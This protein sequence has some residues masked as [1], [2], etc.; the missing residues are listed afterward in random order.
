MEQNEEAKSAQAEAPAAAQAGQLRQRTL[1]ALPRYRSHK[2]VAAA[3][4]I[5]LEQCPDG[6]MLTLEVPAPDGGPGKIEQLVGETWPPTDHP[7]LRSLDLA[8]GCDSKLVGGYYVRYDDDY[9]SWSPSG[10]F[11]NGYDLVCEP[12]TGSPPPPAVSTM[13]RMIESH[14]VNAAN[15]QLHIAVCDDPGSGG[16]NHR[17]EIGGFD[18]QSNPSRVRSDVAEERAQ[19]LLV[20][21]FQ[22]GAIKEAGVNGVTHEALLAIVIDR[23]KAW[24]AGPFAC[25]ENKCALAHLEQAVRFLQARTRRRTEAGA[26][27]THAGT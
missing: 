26:E 3:K 1:V 19:N 4:I 21:L 6:T 27:G 13:R 18:T 10:P 9:E 22:N 5:D 23:M 7:D 16:A 25:D 20:L 14:R 11:A 2:V 8:K 24:Q 12:P 15:D 17:Y